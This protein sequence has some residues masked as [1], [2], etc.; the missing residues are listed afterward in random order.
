MAV[1]FGVAPGLGGVDTDFAV[2]ELCLGDVNAASRRFVVVSVLSR[3]DDYGARPWNEI[4]YRRAVQ[5]ATRQL[6]GETTQRGLL[7]APEG[8]YPGESWH[9][10]TDGIGSRDGRDVS[11]SRQSAG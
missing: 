6:G 8:A 11:T 9:V 5:V 1:A 3:H 2:A 7:D 10:R 4:G